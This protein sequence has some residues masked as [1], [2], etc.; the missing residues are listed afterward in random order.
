MKSFLGSK[1]MTQSNTDSFSLLSPGLNAAGSTK[2]YV[3]EI[4]LLWNIYIIV[5]KVRLGLGSEHFDD[6]TSLIRQTY[7]KYASR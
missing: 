7:V 1:M 4:Y 3:R 6:T 2:R 5:K